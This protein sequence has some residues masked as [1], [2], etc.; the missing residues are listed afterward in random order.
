MW[1]STGS[2]TDNAQTRGG[3]RVLFWVYNTTM[4][5]T[6]LLKESKRQLFWDYCRE[7]ITCVHNKDLACDVEL[8]TGVA[9]FDM[10]KWQQIEN[11]VMSC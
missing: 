4:N 7:N 8:P 1:P 6:H 3:L 11:I 9:L 10:K 2:P 5:D